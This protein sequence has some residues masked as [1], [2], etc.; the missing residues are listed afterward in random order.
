MIWEDFIEIGYI[1]KAHG[2]RGEVKAVLDVHD[3]SEYVGRKTLWIAKAPGKPEPIEVKKI[4]PQD[5]HSIMAF[6]DIHTRNEAEAL[7]GYTL[8]IPEKDLPPLEAGQFYYYEILGFTVHDEQ[9]G[10]L[11]EVAD[12]IEGGLQD[13]IVMRYQ[14]KEVL[15]P[16]VDEV[17]LG[18]DRE[19]KQVNTKLPEGLLEM[20]LEE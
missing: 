7:K 6:K 2:I 13:L 17:L 15:I 11:G 18:I 19:K 10:E 14:N 5:K 20:Y 8:L 3:V 16:A 12:I 1:T 9:H 4:H